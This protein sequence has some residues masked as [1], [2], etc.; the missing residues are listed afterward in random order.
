VTCSVR[1]ANMTMS[2]K[3]AATPAWRATLVTA[4]TG[5]LGIHATGSGGMDSKI[6]QFAYADR[7]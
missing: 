2:M 7:V 4:S 3:A 1:P 6:Y 5:N